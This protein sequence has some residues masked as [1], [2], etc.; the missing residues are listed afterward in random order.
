MNQHGVELRTAASVDVRFHVKKKT[1]TIQFHT[2]GKNY[3]GVT[4]PLHELERLYQ[5]IPRAEFKALGLVVA[6]QGTEE[7]DARAA[8]EDVGQ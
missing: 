2:E 8:D 1:A 5:K 7:P 4:I 3:L 6:E